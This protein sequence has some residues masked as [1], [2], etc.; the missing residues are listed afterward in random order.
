M[1]GG[2]FVV[3]NLTTRDFVVSLQIAGQPTRQVRDHP[4]GAKLSG[5]TYTPP[6]REVVQIAKSGAQRTHRDTTPTGTSSAISVRTDH[7]ISSP[8]ASQAGSQTLAVTGPPLNGALCRPTVM[9]IRRRDQTGLPM[10]NML[11]RFAGQQSGE[12]L[13]RRERIA[14]RVVERIPVLAVFPIVVRDHVVEAVGI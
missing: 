13:E 2:E 8:A 4:P 12:R 1:L 5:F 10:L 9:S 6:R 7:P 11:G 3:E 14:H